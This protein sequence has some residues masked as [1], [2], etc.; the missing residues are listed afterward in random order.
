MPAAKIILPSPHTGGQDRLVY[1]KEQNP[2]AQCLVAPCGTKVGKALALDTPIATPDGWKIMGMLEV[3]DYV[4]GDDGEPTE[5]IETS[6]IEKNRDCYKIYF[7][8]GQTIKADKDHLWSTHTTDNKTPKIK[9][10]FEI[11][12]TLKNDEQP[13]HFINLPKEPL[14]FSQ[15]KLAIDPYYLGQSLARGQK[16]HDV[17]FDEY[18]FSS[19]EQ[20]RQIVKGIWSQKSDKKS[21]ILKFKHPYHKIT[22]FT[23]SLAAS[24]GLNPSKHIKNKTVSISFKPYQVDKK[25]NFVAVTDIKKIDTIPVKC[26]TVDNK[27]KLFLAGKSF[28]PTHNSFGSALWLAK[29][30]LLHAG[31]FAVWVAPTYGKCK[32]GYRYLKSMLD[33]D[34][35]SRCVDG[36]LEISLAN[37]SFIKFLHGR[38]AEV[39]IEG[40]AV[41]LFIL[42]EAAKLNKQVWFSLF[43]TITQTGGIGIITGTPRGFNWYHDVYKKATNGDPF[44]SHLTLRTIDNPYNAQEAIDRAKRLLPKMLY[45]QYYLAKFTS[46]STIFGSLDHI[47]DENLEVPEDKVRFWIHPDK[48]ARGKEVHHGIDL[49]KKRDYTVIFSTNSEGQVVGFARFKSVPYPQQVKRIENYIQKF[50]GHTLDNFIRFD[51]TGIG[52]A[53]G[54]LIY[55]LDIDASITP[56]TFTNASKSDMV[57]RLTLA[58]EQ[59]W[60]K[61]PRIKIFEH[62]MAT[63][64]V[65]ITR[66]GLHSYNASDGEHDDTVCAAMLSVPAAYQSS[67]SID[68]EL[69]L[70]SVESDLYGDLV[71]NKIYEADDFFDEKDE[72][73]DFEMEGMYG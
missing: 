48:D 2:Q 4:L 20:R 44:F 34:G 69:M 33:I 26:I 30:V 16:I 55:D 39:T 8:N 36:K 9:T 38:D 46:A 27:S 3:G 19:I 1:W 28:I 6:Q 7:S 41:D 17:N 45:D 64:E 65:K 10:T 68:S 32:I 29:E 54:D 72:D 5:I 51:V 11:L 23:F 53:V 52:E 63:Y 18:L 62:E 59:K 25:Y 47:W 15:K 37:G 14:K 35:V 49:A 73:D 57:T 12:G 56:V 67:M 42:D 24:L 50:F 71:D 31:M 60:L 66:S 61:A 70:E 40:E 21:S 22:D 43:T 58:I 13:N